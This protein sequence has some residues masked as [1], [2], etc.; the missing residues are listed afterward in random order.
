MTLHELATNAAK[1]GALSATEAILTSRGRM[2]M[3]CSSSFGQRP[4]VHP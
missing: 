2:Q 1:Y 4:A 3:D